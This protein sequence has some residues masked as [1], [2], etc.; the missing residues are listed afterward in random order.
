MDFVARSYFNQIKQAIGKSPILINPY[1]SKV[2]L[3]FSFSS[4]TTIAAML[5]QKNSEEKEQLIAFFSQ[6]LRDVELRYAT[7]KKQAYTLV[8]AL[9]SFRDYFL[10][11]MVIAYV[12]S[13]AIKD[14]LV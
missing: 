10:H 5:L 6:S 12:P 14:I 1:Y 13:I 8:K 11:S 7:V 3:I 4:E 9:K 2:F